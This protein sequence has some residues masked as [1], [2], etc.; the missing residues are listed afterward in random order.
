MNFLQRRVIIDEA[1]EGSA[2]IA[3]IGTS[4]CCALRQIVSCAADEF[5]KATICR[6][7]GTHVLLVG[8]LLGV[9]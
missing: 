7:R 5:S 3:M 8:M 4:Y 6:Y 9:H 2:S 1:A